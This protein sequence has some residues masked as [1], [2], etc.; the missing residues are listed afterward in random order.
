MAKHRSAAERTCATRPVALIIFFKGPLSF[1]AMS[2]LSSP[3]TT[4]DASNTLQAA[5]CSAGVEFPF[6]CNV[7]KHASSTTSHFDSKIS[8]PSL[9]VAY[10]VIDL[11][12]TRYPPSRFV[13]RFSDVIVVA[14]D[15][16]SA[17][18]DARAAAAAI[19]L[20]TSSTLFSSISSSSKSSS[21]NPKLEEPTE[22][23][24][25]VQS[26][27]SSMSRR[28]PSSSVVSWEVIKPSLFFFLRRW[29]FAFFSRPWLAM[30]EIAEYNKTFSVSRTV[31]ELPTRVL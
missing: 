28:T 19:D 16:A 7:Y 18:F 15:S 4:E 17:N 9:P 12:R 31:N 8:V 1:S 30:V 6:P 27:G 29:G 22:E 20:L 26:S 2:S 14:I 10:C 24:A 25:T 5:Y 23:A 11:N 13:A 3:S 21:S